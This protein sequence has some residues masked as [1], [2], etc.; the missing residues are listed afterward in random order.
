MLLRRLRN[1]LATTAIATALCAPAQNHAPAVINVSADSTQITMGGRTI[2]HVEVVKNSHEGVYIDGM[3]RQADSLGNEIMFLGPT[4]VRQLS[5][6]SADIGNG[7]TQVSYNYMVQPFDVGTASF[8]P[9]KFVANGD[10]TYSQTISIK[11]LEPDIPKV[12]RDSLWINPMET[13]VS[14]PSRWY[15]YVPE[16]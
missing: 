15:D 6:D 11:V 9:F 14:I 2:V 10:T 8:G 12:M 3:T 5:A 16:W 4:E 7:R 1:I 13:V